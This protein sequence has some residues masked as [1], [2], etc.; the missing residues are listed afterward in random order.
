[1]AGGLQ[2]GG[3]AGAGAALAVGAGHQHV[4]QAALGVAQGREHGA[5]GVEARAHAHGAAAEKARE[6]GGVVV[7]QH[8]PAS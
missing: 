5:R 1:M 3:H 6:G 7:G 4:G 8:D 2:G